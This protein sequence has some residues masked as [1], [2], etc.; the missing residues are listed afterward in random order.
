M[1]IA[2]IMVC[3]WTFPAAVTL[4]SSL[5]VSACNISVRDGDLHKGWN[6]FIVFSPQIFQ[7]IINDVLNITIGLSS[8]YGLDDQGVEFRVQVGARMFSS[9]V[10]QTGFTANVPHIEWLPGAVFRKVKRLGREAD[11]SLPTSAEVKYMW[12]YISI[13]Q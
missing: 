11:H 7:Y 13:N 2:L 5:L 9:H 1:L 3:N 6:Y 8:D 12:F 10:V 4:L